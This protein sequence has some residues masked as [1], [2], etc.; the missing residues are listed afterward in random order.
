MDKLDKKLENLFE[1]EIDYK[2]SSLEELYQKYYA[3]K[4]RIN[5][6]NQEYNKLPNW[7]DYYIKGDLTTALNILKQID[8]LNTIY[9]TEM[10]D[11]KIDL[12]LLIVAIESLE[13]LNKLR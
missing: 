9:A 5:I 1:S 6:I 3:V 4:N 10:H 7:K 12:N 2:N 13:S 11:L 8:N